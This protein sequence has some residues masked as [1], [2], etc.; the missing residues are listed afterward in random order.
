MGLHKEKYSDKEVE[1]LYDFLSIYH[2]RGEA[3]AFEI[4]VDDFKVVRRTYDLAQFESFKRF[5]RHNSNIV[6]F[7][8]YNGNS[9]NCDKYVL[10]MGEEPE[11]RNT[12]KGKDRGLSGIEVQQLVD[13]KLAVQKQQWEMQL[14][15]EKI[16]TLTQKCTAQEQEIKELEGELEQI[17]EQRAEDLSR[18]SPFK[19]L[20]GDVGAS[21][22]ESV[23]RRNPKTIA[24]IIPGGEQL[25]GLLDKDERERIH[26]INNPEAQEAEVVFSE[27]S[28]SSISDDP[29]MQL[30]SGLRKSFSEDEFSKLL[31]V[32]DAMYEDPSRLHTIYELIKE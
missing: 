14:M 27:K 1:R 32:L 4:I 31:K 25:A 9:N 8:F 23:I 2:E 20:L 28:T 21:I 19:S 30:I 18:E 5:L 7:N 17:Q 10:Y 3:I 16:K 24:G 6:E 22:V 15:V 12:D 29:A 26:K 13:E 11:T